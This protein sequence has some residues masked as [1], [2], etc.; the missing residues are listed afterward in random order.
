MGEVE[1]RVDV[2]FED[3]PPP[4]QREVRHRLEHRG[5]GVVDE[6][7]DRAAERVD[8][9]GDDAGAVVRIGQVGRD[10]RDG[11]SVPAES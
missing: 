3:H 5:R 7:L 9:V 8:R 11:P 2:P 1:G 10:D 6:D 4:L